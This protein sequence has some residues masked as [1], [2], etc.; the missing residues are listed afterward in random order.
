MNGDD[1]GMTP[2]D[3]VATQSRSFRHLGLIG[4]VALVTLAIGG[5]TS[6]GDSG[7]GVVADGGLD[8][9]Q[10]Q[11]NDS[12]EPDIDHL[13]TA[14]VVCAEA[15]RQLTT[16]NGGS[17]VAI[18]YCG[19]QS[20]GNGN[21]GMIFQLNDPVEWTTLMASQPM[22]TVLFTFPLGL[23]AYAFGGS[24]RDPETFD[25]VLIAFN[26]MN[27]TV[28]EIEA[29]DLSETLNAQTQE[30]ATNSLIALSNKMTITSL[31]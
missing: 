1:E 30:E 15:R 24:N 20:D 23:A 5:C 26:D 28:Y 2:T 31:G 17:E 4:F 8:S 22:E 14:E 25:T 7:D 11:A 29:S 27:Q 21:I 12:D 13:A 3:R 10:S 16:A 18:T 6:S 9:A 19:A